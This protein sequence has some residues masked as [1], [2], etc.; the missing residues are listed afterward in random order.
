MA[1]FRVRAC[2]FAPATAVVALDISVI[3]LAEFHHVKALLQ[4]V[5]VRDSLL[6]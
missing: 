2:F 5:A 1:V 6:R 4:E 3:N